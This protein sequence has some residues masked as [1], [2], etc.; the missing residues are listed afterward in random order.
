MRLYVLLALVG[1]GAATTPSLLGVLIKETIPV[2]PNDTC[3][4][5]PE[6]MR[7]D[8]R[9]C[10][11]PITNELINCAP[12]S[13]LEG[14]PYS[15]CA[16]YFN[17]ILSRPLW[18]REACAEPYAEHVGFYC[19]L[20]QGT[21]AYG[22]CITWALIN[23]NGTVS[24]SQCSIDAQLE[25]LDIVQEATTTLTRTNAAHQLPPLWAP[26]VDFTPFFD[27]PEMQGIVTLELHMH[28]D[29]ADVVLQNYE[30][31]KTTVQ[32]LGFGDHYYFCHPLLTHV[33]YWGEHRQLA[34]VL[35][36]TVNLTETTSYKLTFHVQDAFHGDKL[37]L[38]RVHYMV[39]PPGGATTACCYAPTP[40]CLYDCVF[41]TVD[42]TPIADSVWRV[43]LSHIPRHEDQTLRQIT[44]DDTHLQNNTLSVINGYRLVPEAQ[45]RVPLSFNVSGYEPDMLTLALNTTANITRLRVIVTYGYGTCIHVVAAVQPIANCTAVEPVRTPDPTAP[46]S[47]TV[48]PALTLNN[49]QA[50]LMPSVEIWTMPTYMLF[51]G[52]VLNTTTR[53]LY[54]THVCSMPLDTAC[55]T[56]ESTA[57]MYQTVDFPVVVAYPPQLRVAVCAAKQEYNGTVEV[58]KVTI[59]D[60]LTGTCPNGNYTRNMTACPG[61]VTFNFTG[62]DEVVPLPLPYDIATLTSFDLVLTTSYIM[63]PM[64]TQFNR[65]MS[66]FAAGSEPALQ[67]RA[68][69]YT[70][71]VTI[72]RGLA[73]LEL[74]FGYTQADTPYRVSVRPCGDPA[75]IG[76]PCAYNNSKFD[77]PPIRLQTVR[78]PNPFVTQAGAPTVAQSTEPVAYAGDKSVLF[79]TSAVT[80]YE[81]KCDQWPLAFNTIEGAR[82]DQLRANTGNTYATGLL[83]LSAALAQ[84]PGGPWVTRSTDS[85]YLTRTVG[86]DQMPADNWVRLGDLIIGQP[87]LYT[88]NGNVDEGT[89]YPAEYENAGPSLQLTGLQVP[90]PR[91]IIAQFAPGTN[92]VVRWIDNGGSRLSQ[93]SSIMNF[94]VQDVGLLRINPPP[95]EDGHTYTVQPFPGTYEHYNP[96]VDCFAAVPRYWVI[97]AK[98]GTGINGWYPVLPGDTNTYR[99]TAYVRDQNAAFLPRAGDLL[100]PNTRQIRHPNITTLAQALTKYNTAYYD[101]LLF[102]ATQRIAGTVNTN[103]TFTGPY[104]LL[105]TQNL[106]DDQPV[107]RAAEDQYCGGVNVHTNLPVA[108]G[109]AA[110]ALSNE[111][112]VFKHAS[113]SIKISTNSAC[114]GRSSIIAYFQWNDCNAAG[115]CAT[116]Q[117]ECRTPTPI[118]ALVGSW[119]VNNMQIWLPGS[120][121]SATRRRRFS[122]LEVIFPVIGIADLIDDKM[123]DTDDSKPPPPPPPP[124]PFGGNGWLKDASDQWICP[125]GNYLFYTT[126]MVYCCESVSGLAS[127]P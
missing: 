102:E 7:D 47:H 48:P 40:R 36:V 73:Q 71:H 96:K 111:E 37:Y 119:F 79:Y 30:R 18:T 116:I 53:S 55:N 25:I 92:V 12:T 85:T 88:M 35:N 68:E 82:L 22:T 76:C 99:T 54:V 52:W 21:R 45:M 4:V 126:S 70:L 11:V 75:T 38:D 86:S 69:P 125:S 58:R 66:I 114:V 104:V 33:E 61:F 56:Y 124:I 110:I 8:A 32:L 60:A 87:D 122:P 80:G 105:P 50:Y 5:I 51:D 77:T 97:R 112:M 6:Y 84:L 14:I 29:L 65:T 109:P 46:C 39:C 42:P 94:N 27:R 121:T 49:T 13:S 62:I 107:Y 2:A 1:L 83:N 26:S 3:I 59:Q 44:V 120:G 24:C 19:S 23:S 17:N 100:V 95:K 106:K 115:Q 16:R 72:P 93:T 91:A 113:T 63:I 117:I 15:W 101:A 78:L 20:D 10:R 74:H 103:G 57:P 34:F 64:P 108:V 89:F 118:T 127:S 123:D 9:L 90:I 67:G 81:D 98:T 31:G 41:T 28:M 43:N